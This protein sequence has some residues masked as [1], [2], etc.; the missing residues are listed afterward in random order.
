MTSTSL[1]TLLTTMF[2][3]Y[4]T[5]DVTIIEMHAWEHDGI[6]A[7]KIGKSNDMVKR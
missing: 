6:A 4:I 7:G 3:S 2:N 1:Q 5:I